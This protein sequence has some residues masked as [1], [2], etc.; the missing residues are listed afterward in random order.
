MYQSLSIQKRKS[1]LGILHIKR[2]TNREWSMEWKAVKIT[3][4]TVIKNVRRSSSQ[5]GGIGR[6]TL[7]PR[8]TKTR[9]SSLFIFKIILLLFNYSYL[10][11][12]PT[13]ILQPSQNP[14]PPF[15]PPYWFCLF[16]LHSSYWKHFP[17][18]SLPTC[19]LVNVRL[20]LVSVSL[21]TFFFCLL[22]SS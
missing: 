22:C 17:W 8:T 13:A 21:V 5:D 4:R 11:F 7:L 10:Y 20:F 15:H 19:P 3:E 2:S 14:L 12:P 9:I 1:H 18:L 6:N 16:V